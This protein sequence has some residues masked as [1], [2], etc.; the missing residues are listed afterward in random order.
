MDK[1]INIGLF[2][3]AFF[4]MIDGVG[5]VVDNYAKRLIKYA[6]VYVFA[7]NYKEEYDDSVFP[8]HVIRC[9]SIKVPFIDYSLPMPKL[10]KEFR[11]IVNS[12][13]LDIV[14]IHSPFTIGKAGV[15]Y[16]KRYHVPLIGT[17]HSQYKQD[18]KRA[19]RNDLLASKLTNA[20]IS[21]YNK[22]DECWAVNSEVARI[23]YEDYGYKCLPKVMNNATEMKPLIDRKKAYDLINKKHNLKNEKVF[24]FVGRINNLKNVFFIVDAL[25]ELEK[26]NPDLEYKML[27]IGTGQDE[28]ELRRRIKNYN[29]ED[30]IIMCGKVTD[31][32]LLASY[33][34]RSDLFLFPSYYDASSIVQIEAASQ[35][36]PVLFLKGSATSATVTDNV[37][38][39]ICENDIRKYAERINTIISSKELLN[40]VSLNAYNNLYKNWDD[41][42][43]DVYHEYLK[44]ID[45][46]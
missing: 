11:K 16:A 19:V 15:S 41:L 44:L 4:P 12:Y 9:K 42:V 10:D 43:E 21:V 7:P 5:M 28:E 8:Y 24:I 27:F 45:N 40:N 34:V 1:K 26:V 32:E 36:T 13:K 22:C 18:F 35:K 29:L 23:F 17:M 2:T 33:Y 6:N 31:R 3:D 14:H 46:K 20:L 39:F 30:K 37:D 25:K 38:G